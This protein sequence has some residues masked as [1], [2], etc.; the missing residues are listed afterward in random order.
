MKKILGIM[1]SPRK[2][3]NT[4]VLV[5]E[6]LKG[7]KKEGAKTNKIYLKNKIIRECNGCHVCWEGKPCNK[8]DDMNKL[9]SKIAESDCIIFGTPVYWYGPTALIKAMID[10]FVYF[11]CPE[12]R[13]EIAGKSAVIIVPYEDKDPE[14][15]KPIVDFFTKCFTYLEMNFV[16]KVIVPG[17]TKR[18]EVTEKTD[19]MEQCLKIGERL[20]C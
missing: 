9:Y 5:S 2:G 8:K 1:G 13:I 3:G 11:N 12:N 20:S 10:R 6:M 7:A 19:V 17:V 14:T 15:A 18:G 16:E 4:D